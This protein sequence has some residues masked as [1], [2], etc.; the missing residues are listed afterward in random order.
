[1]RSVISLCILLVTAAAGAYALYTAYVDRSQVEV[2]YSD[3]GDTTDQINPTTSEANQ[4]DSLTDRTDT[5][6]SL[7]ALL[8]EQ[9][10][11]LAVARNEIVD[12]QRRILLVETALAQSSLGQSASAMA[13][14][15]LPDD[16]RFREQN[17]V[18]EEDALVHRH[19]L[20]LDTRFFHELID[21]AWAEE[22]SKSLDSLAAN[23]T[24][25]GFAISDIECRST[26]CRLV[27][28]PLADS[29]PIN[30]L[31]LQVALPGMSE[32]LPT[33]MTF[34]QPDGTTTYFFSRAGYELQDN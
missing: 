2:A 9:S 32:A 20:R 25:L 31:D 1:M 11:E 5:F 24:D 26:L 15:H 22:M 23:S 8:R 10:R 19:R 4:I 18:T 6:L 30:V 16:I 14:L 33:A 29:P 21:E 17:L 27:V 13:P 34:R 7:T 3:N 12:L 28:Q